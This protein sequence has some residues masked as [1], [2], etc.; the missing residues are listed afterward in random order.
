MPAATRYKSIKRFGPRYGR[1]T[2]GKIGKVEEERK[3]S[4]NCPYC[5]K[6]RVKRI[7][8]GIWH[9]GKCN[10]KFA[11]RAYSLGE[12]TITTEKLIEAETEKK[13]GEE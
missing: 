5:H 4:K 9:C 11:G 7:A 8:S 10:S 13:E 3:L 12:R 6:P 1:K 2:K